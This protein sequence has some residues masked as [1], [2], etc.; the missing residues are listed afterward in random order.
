MCDMIA[1]VRRKKDGVWFAKNSDRDANEAQVLEWHGAQTHPDGARLKCTWIEIPQVPA[2][3]ATLLS[4]PF[5]MWGAE[6]GANEHNVVVGNVA[7]FTKQPYAKE[8]LTGMDLVRLALERARTAK[9]ASEV[10]LELM[11][12]HGQGGSCSKA[13]P[14]MTYHNSFILVDPEGAYLLETAGKEHAL[15]PIDGTRTV[16]NTLMIPSMAGANRDGLRTRISRALVRQARTHHLG[17]KTVT[18]RHLFA[19]L[20]DHGSRYSNPRYHFAIGGMSAV[21]MH[22]GGLIANAQTVGS[23]VTHMSKDGAIRH[24]VTG[25]PAPCTSIFKPVHVNQPVDLGPLPTDVADAQSL[26]WRH[27]RFHRKLM[28]NPEAQREAF[29]PERNAIEAD[30]VETPPDSASAFRQGDELLAKW[31]DA[32]SKTEVSD[33]RPWWSKRF[34]RKQDALAHIK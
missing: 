23:W 20:R 33:V 16:S 9:E 31:L 12:K 28:I 11:G 3:F 15:E 18:E 4:R 25:T 5:W 10:I 34:W 13:H 21:C 8:G 26:W 19:A 32:I 27:S 6:M 22:A 29:V 7:V 14:S 1:L 30:W 24:W 17:H 2:T